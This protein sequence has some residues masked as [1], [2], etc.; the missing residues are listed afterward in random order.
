MLTKD[1][2]INLVK[3]LGTPQSIID[4]MI[5][6][7]DV[8][9]HL[10]D[11]AID[12]GRQVDRDVIQA[13]CLTHDI[14][15][16]RLTQEFIVIPEYGADFKVEVDHLIHF[17]YSAQMIKELG[18][19]E[20]VQLCALRHIVGPNNAECRELGW[21]ELEKEAV[22][23]NDSEELM[24]F[25]DFLVWMA[26]TG[27]NPWLD[28]EAPVKAGWPFLNAMYQFYTGHGIS[29]EHPFVQR[30]IT[31]TDRWLPLTEVEFLPPELQEKIQPGT[32]IQ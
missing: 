19:P 5:Q 8:A 17:L 16:P 14:G 31:L 15:I 6:V 30:Y 18:L 32:S 7:N 23:E 12:A 25:A 21:P 28:R 13:A 2:I 1:E 4:H 22:P 3:N 27:N 9:M 11:A 24:A 26:R 20:A 10:V 29:P